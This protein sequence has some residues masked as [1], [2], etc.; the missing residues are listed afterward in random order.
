MSNVN[1]PDVQACEAPV[2]IAINRVGIDSL[3]LPIYID[4][5]K[6]GQQHTVAE[7]S[8]YVD[9]PA[10]KKGINMSRLPIAIH[11]FV[12][13]QLN[14]DLLLK[15]ADHIRIKSEAD[16]CELTYKFPY[17]MTKHAPVSHE[18]GTLHYMVE[19]NA[20]VS[21]TE[22]KFRFSVQSIATTLCPCSKEMSE[23]N[24]HNQK[25]YITIDVNTDG[26]VWIE[27]IIQIA[28]ES[29]SCE[30][31]SVLKRPDEKYVTDKMY[32]N[33]R[34]VEDVVREVYKRMS[35]VD[36]IKGFVV[37]AAA[38]ESIHMHR[39]YAKLEAGKL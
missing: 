18:P 7:V 22:Q 26:W 32:E 5:K 16:V 14:G 35:C 31:Y 25:C 15:I 38:D 34:F 39:A 20:V 8:C 30:I 29:A 37:E 27:D 6:G 21:E 24:A 10:D 12:K 9:L 11:K 17:F 3:K 33:P 13:D 23:A 36:N 28:E 1:L 4:E 19:F 2:A